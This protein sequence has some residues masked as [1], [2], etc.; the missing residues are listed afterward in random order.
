MAPM[1]RTVH[2]LVR[3]TL[4]VSL[5]ACTQG[6]PRVEP[7]RSTR[8]AEQ[9]Q[10]AL[11]SAAAGSIAVQP[12]KPRDVRLPQYIPVNS[13]QRRKVTL[14][15]DI[16]T[17]GRVVANRTR[18]RGTTDAALAARLRESARSYRFWPAVANGCAVPAT[19]EMVFEL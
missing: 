13:P 6:A 4:A 10:A 11:D 1:R 18:V 14:T 15:L 9:C 3:L 7:L 17:A 5:T 8:P 12:P 16:D 19:Y 2:D